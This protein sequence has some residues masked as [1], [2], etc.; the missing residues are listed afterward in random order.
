MVRQGE[1]DGRGILSVD[2]ISHVERVSDELLSKGL[3]EAALILCS[4][5]SLSIET[6]RIIAKGLGTEKVMPSEL[7]R[8]AGRSPEGVKSLD[9]AIEVSLAD[10]DINGH[11]NQLIVVTQAPLLGMIKH[12]DKRAKVPYDQ[13]I[14]YVPGSWVNP[15]YDS[16]SFSS[17]DFELELDITRN[18]ITQRHNQSK[19]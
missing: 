7:I 2:G 17:Q 19:R 1:D 4:N 5:V 18:K 3:G 13:I 14:G 15:D 6:A 12:R 9:N 8:V 10:W 11:P 16:K